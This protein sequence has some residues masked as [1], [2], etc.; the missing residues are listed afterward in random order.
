MLLGD[1][2]RPVEAEATQA[3]GVLV[4]VAV[5]TDTLTDRRVRKHVAFC[6]RR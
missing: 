5:E 2:S 3:V 1:R 4:V 6:C